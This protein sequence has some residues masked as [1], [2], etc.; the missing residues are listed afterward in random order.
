MNQTPA[1]TVLLPV[2]NSAEFLAEAIESILSQTFRDFELL[3]I[4]DASE[5]NSIDVIRSFSD[6]RIRLVKNPSRM[7]L[8]GTLNSGLALARGRYIARMDADDVS[9]PPRLARQV[10][11]LDEHPDIGIVGSW[12]QTIGQTGGQIWRLPGED[13][14]IRCSL[15]FR[16]ALAHPTVMIRKAALI[17]AGLTYDPALTR[18]QDYDLWARCSGRVAMANVPQVLLHYRVH[19]NQATRCQQADSLAA[20]A[21]VRLGLI[22]Q[23]GRIPHA[24]EVEIHEALSLGQLPPDEAF[25]RDADAWLRKLYSANQ[26]TGIYPVNALS[27]V[28]TGRWVTVVRLADSL[29]LKQSLLS[30]EDCPFVPYLHAG[31]I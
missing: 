29:G 6:S 1:L 21:R 11:F 5:D 26:Q 13:A 2:H 9:L 12:V 25:I 31:A 23:L 24:R 4:D 19:S 10:A 20:A 14:D 30:F 28:L 27:R 18:A 8:P 22:R 15:L 17:E 3:L 7:E 16:N